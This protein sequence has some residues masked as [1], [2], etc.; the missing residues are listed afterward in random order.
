[1][2][3]NWIRWTLLA[4]ALFFAGW[5]GVEEWKRNSAPVI[6]LETMPVDPRD[7]FAGQ[8]MALRYRIGQVDH[9]PGFP[10]EKPYGGVKIAVL[11]KPSGT[12]NVGGKG[13]QLWGAVQCQVQPPEDLG[14]GDGLWVRG[15]WVSSN[16]VIFGIE[17]Y[18]FS[19]KR[20]VELNSVNTGHVYVEAKV[21]KGG[22]LALKDLVY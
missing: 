21:M 2:K 12:V 15:E 13:H 6:L 10:Q 7:L 11:L 8:Y 17:R 22:K 5:A 1:M 3:K 9:L 16:N 4:Q 19:E 14:T 20:K 18:Y